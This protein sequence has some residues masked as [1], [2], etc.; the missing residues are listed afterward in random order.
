MKKLI[1]FL[2]EKPVRSCVG[3]ALIVLGLVAGLCGMGIIPAVIGAI[4]L[5]D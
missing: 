2:R 4:V 3:L 1:N 5:A